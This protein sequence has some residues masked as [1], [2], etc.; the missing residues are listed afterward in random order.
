MWANSTWTRYTY[1]YT[2]HCCLV[3][4]CVCVCVCVHACVWNGYNW[5][6]WFLR[7]LLSSLLWCLHYETNT[8]SP[9]YLE[10]LTNWSAAAQGLVSQMETVMC[11]EG[12]L[13]CRKN[14]QNKK[15][16]A[17]AIHFSTPF[18]DSINCSILGSESPSLLTSSFH[19]FSFMLWCFWDIWCVWV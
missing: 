8:Q 9:P 18:S 16:V 10:C 2:E 15:L 12:I 4:V 11:L 3:C 17:E 6:Y 7:C 13:E 14:P 19:L 5:C 1:I